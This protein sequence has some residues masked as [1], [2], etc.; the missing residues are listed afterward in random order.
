MRARTIAAGVPYTIHVPTPETGQVYF[1]AVNSDLHRVLMLGQDGSFD[2]I[3]R[4]RFTWLSG[5]NKGETVSSYSQM[6]WRKPT[7]GERR[8]M[9]TSTLLP[10]E[11]QK[12]VEGKYPGLKLEWFTGE[13]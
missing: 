11:K 10:Y 2:R 8:S 3:T 5:P 7:M 13:K 1:A 6:F 4:Y 12:L 9:W